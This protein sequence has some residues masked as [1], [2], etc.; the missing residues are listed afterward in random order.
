MTFRDMDAIEQKMGFRVEMM[1]PKQLFDYNAMWYE[2]MFRRK[3]PQD[4]VRELSLYRRF[5][6]VY[7]SDAGRISKWIWYHYKGEGKTDGRFQSNWYRANLKWWHD[8]LLEEVRLELESTSV[9]SLKAQKG[10]TTA[11]D[12]LQ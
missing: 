7:G 5:K 12:L 2:R 6:K 9:E 10:F 11:K 1:D 8:K 4:R 3:L